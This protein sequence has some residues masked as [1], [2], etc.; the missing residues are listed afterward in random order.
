MTFYQPRQK[1]A[2]VVE[3]VYAMCGSFID[4]GYGATANSQGIVIVF[5][6][7]WDAL[8]LKN[9]DEAKP[10]DFNSTFM[11][12]SAQQMLV[13]ILERANEIVQ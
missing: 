11:H 2:T 12:D 13:T 4:P 7:L 9:T 10:Y 6:E 5:N 3:M 1:E 8:G